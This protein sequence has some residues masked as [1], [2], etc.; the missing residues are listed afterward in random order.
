ME[1]FTDQ[2][3]VIISWQW[4]WLSTENMLTNNDCVYGSF[5]LDFYWLWYWPLGCLPWFLEMRPKNVP[6]FIVYGH[7]LPHY[8]FLPWTVI[9]PIVFYSLADW[10]MAAQGFLTN[11]K[12]I[13]LRQRIIGTGKSNDFNV[14][15][16]FYGYFL[17]KL[18]LLELI[19]VLYLFP[20]NWLVNIIHCPE[21]GSVLSV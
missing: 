11:S 5:L 14:R 1:Y 3:Y 17:G 2:T 18:V 10:P 12:C 7:V 16:F 4:H 6:I 21:K 15:Q 13:E 20:A 19:F 8:C 9:T